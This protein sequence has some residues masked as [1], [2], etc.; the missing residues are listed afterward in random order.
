MKKRLLLIIV[1]LLIA[2]IAFSGCGNGTD[3]GKKD[4]DGKETFHVNI[5]AGRPGDMWFALSH[6]LATFINEESDWLTADVVTTAGV[7]DNTRFLLGDKEAQKTHLNVTMLPGATFWGEDEYMPLQITMLLMLNETWVTLD[8]NIKTYADFEGKTVVIPRDAPDAYSWI[9]R[10]MVQLAGVKNVRFLHGGIEDRLTALRD[11]AGQVGVLPF[12]YFH[13]DEYT[14]SASLIELGARSTLHFPNQ[15]DLEKNLAL[16][17]KACKSDP[18]AGIKEQPAMG[19]IA[20]KE[21]FGKTQTEQIAYVATPVYWS[22]GADM[23]EEVVY[24]ITRIIYEAAKADK[25]T[26]YH[27]MGKGITPEFVAMSY[28]KTDEEKEKYYHPG[29]LK[30]FSDNNISLKYFLDE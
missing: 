30:F 11:G 29:A 1:C 5:A 28:W 2:A 18:F 14:L 8:P 20:R 25:F 15:G 6:A 23:P 16:I 7:A 4:G 13:P 3:K 10:N 17:E 26:A 22:A 24:E 9:F 27:N 12:D 19:M 21:A